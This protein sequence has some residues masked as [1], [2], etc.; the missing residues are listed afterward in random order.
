M[1][2]VRIWRAGQPQ[3]F[4]VPEQLFLWT[5]PSPCRMRQQRLALTFENG[6]P[7]AL[8][9]ARMSAVDLIDRLNFLAGSFG[10]GRHSGL[11]HLA[12]GEKVLEVREAPAAAVI[13]DAHRHV[14]SAALD[15]EVLREKIGM[16]QLWV[17]EAVEGRWFGALRS[18]CDAFIADTSARVSG[19]VEYVLRDGAADVC[20]IKADNPRYLTDRDE[21]ERSK[22]KRYSGFPFAALGAT[23]SS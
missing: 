13:L 18:A 11:E 17:R 22:A 14:E 2:R 9:D 16:E 19:R 7:V 23:E 3:E 5:A 15:A 12:G 6:V 21:W 10:I 1:P 20:S 4:E 8:N